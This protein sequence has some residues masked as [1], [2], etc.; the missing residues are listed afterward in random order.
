MLFLP[1]FIVLFLPNR[2]ARTLEKKKKEKKE[3][4]S[5]FKEP[6]IISGMEFGFV[7]VWFEKKKKKA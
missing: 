6:R 3:L 5:G 1:W 4:A 2:V 7:I